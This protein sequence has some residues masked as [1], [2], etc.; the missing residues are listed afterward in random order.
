MS[1]E[2]MTSFLSSGTNKA[3]PETTDFLGN[4]AAQMAIDASISLS[5]AVVKVASG[6]PGLNNT[7]IQNICWVA[8]NEYFRKVAK[9]REQAGEN[10]RDLIDEYNDVEIE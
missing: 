2:H 4:R 3:T 10:L 1:L 9:S 5:D 7:H 8:N 6:H